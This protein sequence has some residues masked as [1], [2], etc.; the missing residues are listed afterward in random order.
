[1]DYAAQIVGAGRMLVAWEVG[2]EP[3]LH[4]AAWSPAGL[5]VTRHGPDE[6]NPI[7]PPQL[8]DA[9]MLCTGAGADGNSIYLDRNGAHADWTGLP[10]HSGLARLI[11]GVGLLS[12]PIRSERLSGHVFLTDLTAPT[13][14]LMTLAGVVAREIGTSLEQI[15]LGEQ[16]QDIAASEQRLRVARDLH[17]GVLQS[18]TGIRLELQDVASALGA[19][20]AELL[21]RRLLAIE[22]TLAIEQ[23]ELRLFIDSLKP[24]AEAAVENALLLTLDAL[25]ERV[26][27]EWK[28][29]LTIR[30]GPRVVSIPD[31]IERAIPPMVHEAVVNALKHGD[32]S[33]I[34]VDLDVDNGTLR[35]IVA[36][37]GHGFP[38]LGRFDHDALADARLGPASLRD[39]AAS[40]GGR[41]TIDSH[42][43]GSRVEI[44]LPVVSAGV[45]V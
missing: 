18:L 10:L 3:W 35:I 25:K 36:D 34:R 42:A 2:D 24:H 14:E 39:R 22:R 7:V 37:D 15:A 6:F 43:S 40:L 19:D 20:S 11:D 28:V 33:R 9:I 5:T 31:T 13:A 29:P 4:L 30:V 32:P 26:A 8:T 16:L 12:A 21:R 38:F 44:A 1:L 17:D 23:R 41:L 27:L 45:G